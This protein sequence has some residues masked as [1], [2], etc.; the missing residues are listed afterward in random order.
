L[1]A[2]RKELIVGAVLAIVIVIALGGFAQFA[3]QLISPTPT[4]TPYPTPMPTPTPGPAPPPKLNMSADFASLKSFNVTQRESQGSLYPVLVLPP[5]GSGSIPI[6]LVSTGDEDYTISLDIGLS[7]VDPKFRGVRYVFSPST[8][9]LKA[10]GE[11]NSILSIEADPDAPYILYDPS[12]S[13]RIEEW[14]RGGSIGMSFFDLLI[15]PHTPLYA[16]EI[17]APTPGAPEPSPGG[18]PPILPPPTVSVKPGE[19]LYIMFDVHKGTP[20]PSIQVKLS[21]THDSGSLPS[22]IG[23]EFNTLEPA[24]TPSYQSVIILALTTT[25]DVREGKYRMVSTISVGSYTTE[26]AFDLT[27]T[28]KPLI[29]ATLPLIVASPSTRFSYE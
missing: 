11:V 2:Y 14:E 28:S 4:P 24:S 27:V 7:G 29:T 16:Y 25:E 26:R 23:A 3:P 10:G 13:A 9:K 18:E 17:F 5:G 15:Y 1:S 22:G 6:R 8:L 19:K 20:D 21:L 12:I